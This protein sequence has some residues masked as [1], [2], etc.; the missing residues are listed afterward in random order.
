MEIAEE[1]PWKAVATRAQAF[2]KK[3][4]TGITTE[5]P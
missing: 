1:G 3:L 4:V 2:L 5:C